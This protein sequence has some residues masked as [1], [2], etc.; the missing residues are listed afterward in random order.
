MDWSAFR[1]FA[2]VLGAQRRLRRPLSRTTAEATPPAR[3]QVA[4]H[5]GPSAVG[6]RLPQTAAF[7]QSGYLAPAGSI[8]LRRWRVAFGNLCRGLSPAA[9][10]E[11]IAMRPI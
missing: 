7:V 3:R 2:S 6:A 4:P 9:R 11:R 5:L 10:C 1:P 8:S